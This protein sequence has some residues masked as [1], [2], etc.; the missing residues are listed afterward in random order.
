MEVCESL[1]TVAA[2]VGVGN[3]RSTI[4]AHNG[5]MATTP[6]TFSNFNNCSV[7]SPTYVGIYSK[8]PPTN[9]KK[10]QLS[11]SN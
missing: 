8:F 11:R 9:R 1:R 2:L 10:I 3:E 6:S 7:D 5:L 4:L